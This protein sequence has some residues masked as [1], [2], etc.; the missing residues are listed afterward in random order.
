VV[1]DAFNNLHVLHYDPPAAVARGAD[2]V[3]VGLVHKGDMNLGTMVTCMVGG[4][5]VVPMVVMHVQ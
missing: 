2:D 4:S 5:C 1:S 3:I